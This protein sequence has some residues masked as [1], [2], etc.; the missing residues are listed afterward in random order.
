TK[1]LMYDGRIAEDFKLNTGTFVNVG[2]LRN[3]VLI[4]GNLLIQDVN[5]NL[6][7]WFSSRVW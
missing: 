6:A 4:Q 1:G 7:I 5:K 2:T 3:K